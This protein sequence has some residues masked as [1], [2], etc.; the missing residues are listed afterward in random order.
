VPISGFPTR[1]HLGKGAAF[2]SE[3]KIEGKEYVGFP[4]PLIHV[5]VFLPP[6]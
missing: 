4:P 1:E 6:A 5:N 2:E 3:F